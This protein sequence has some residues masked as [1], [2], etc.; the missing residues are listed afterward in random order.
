MTQPTARL[1]PIDG[2]LRITD[3]WVIYVRQRTEDIRKEDIQ[4]L[5]RQDQRVRMVGLIN[6]P[7]GPVCHADAGRNSR[8]AVALLVLVRDK[9]RHPAAPLI[10]SA[11]VSPSCRFIA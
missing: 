11:S 7:P 5:I 9:R 1:R 3:T 4:R 2:T 6:R 8:P 10:S